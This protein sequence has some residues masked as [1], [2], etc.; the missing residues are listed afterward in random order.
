MEAAAGRDDRAG[1]AAGRISGG[2]AP[3]HP[4]AEAGERQKDRQPHTAMIARGAADD[5]THRSDEPPSHL[6]PASSAALAISSRSFS[7]PVA[8][9]ADNGTSTDAQRIT[10]R[11]SRDG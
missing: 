9:T 3:H 10:S 11:S 8:S 4:R 1:V 6:R 5:P 7:V 2:E